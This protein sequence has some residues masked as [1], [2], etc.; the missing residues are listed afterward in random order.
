MGARRPA[1]RGPVTR[2]AP[3]RG[4][5]PMAPSRAAQEHVPRSWVPPSPALC[6]P[7]G[8]IRPVSAVCW[9]RPLQVRGPGAEQPPGDAGRP[10]LL[11]Q[12]APAPVLRRQQEESQERHPEDYRRHQQG[13]GQEAGAAGMA[14]WAPRPPLGLSSAD[15]GPRAPGTGWPLGTV[16]TGGRQGG[17]LL[18]ELRTQLGPPRPLLATPPPPPPEN[19]APA[20]KVPEGEQRGGGGQVC[21]IRSGKDHGSCRARPLRGWAGLA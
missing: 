2:G 15:R 12:P 8:R 6:G 21:R 18:A 17:R 3:R 13:G 11:E 10:A 7:W 1:P 14:P 19:P 16:H 20:W 5:W 9:V 4:P